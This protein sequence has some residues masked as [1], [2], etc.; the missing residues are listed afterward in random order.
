MLKNI[1]INLKD[2]FILWNQKKNDCPRTKYKIRIKE[3]DIEEILRVISNYKEV[4][5]AFIFGSRVKG[6]YRNGSDVDIALK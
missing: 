6:N 1:P 4:E 2:N 5:S 3:N